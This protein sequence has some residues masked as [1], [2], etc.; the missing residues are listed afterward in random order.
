[1]GQKIGL[2]GL[3]AMGLPMGKRLLGA[4][5]DLFVVPHR[6]MAPAEELASLGAQVREKPAQLA[7]ECSVVITSVPDVPHVSSVLFGRDGVGLERHP[8]LLYIDM[9]TI[10][11]S[12][13]RD[14]SRRLAELEV[15]AIDAPV[16][17]GP[18]RA[19]DGTL[20]IMV[21][22]ATE[23]VER[24]GPVLQVLGKHIIH[25]GESG[26]GQAVK[27]V[28]QL[29]IS[30]VMVA[31]AEALTLG[32]KAGVPLETM[33]EVI[34]TSSGSNY[35]MQSWMPKTLFSGDLNG[36]FALELLMKD[37]NAALQWANEMGAPTFGGSMAQQL[38]KL[39]RAEG[40][41]RLDYSAVARIYERSA[42]IEL[43]LA[44]GDTS[45]G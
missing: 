4:G 44:P 25:V 35:L 27:L 13:A 1:M 37:L 42:G 23:A 5:Y 26:A 2:I 19:V 21:G 34:G 20:T 18:T 11:P 36:G 6:N 28:N 32:V 39:M 16:S 17:G 8:G 14:F 10:T 29:I 7:D 43:R 33:M 31:N 45:P 41:E 3:G 22:G 40:A 24:A 12:A 30:I 15:A 38:Y 9:S